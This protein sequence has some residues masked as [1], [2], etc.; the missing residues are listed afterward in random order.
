MFDPQYEFNMNT[1][2]IPLCCDIVPRLF[3]R[4][5]ALVELDIVYRDR[6]SDALR[7][8]PLIGL[9][10]ANIHNAL[11]AT[12]RQTESERVGLNLFYRSDL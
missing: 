3:F 6:F 7:L 2:S 4:F 12:K 11:F 1:I 9:D 8:L 10:A 5:S